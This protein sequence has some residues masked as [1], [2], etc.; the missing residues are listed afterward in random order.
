MFQLLSCEGSR[1][2]SPP[3]WTLWTS[4]WWSASSLSSVRK[5]SKSLLPAVWPDCTQ[6]LWWSMQPSCSSSRR[7]GDPGRQLTRVWSRSFQWWL[8]GPGMETSTR[9]SNGQKGKRF[10][11]R[12]NLVLSSLLQCQLSVEHENYQPALPG[13]VCRY[14]YY[15]LLLTTLFLFLTRLSRRRTLTLP[16]AAAMVWPG[17]CPP[18]PRT[19]VRMRERREVR[20]AIFAPWWSLDPGPS[21]SKEW[22]LVT[23]NIILTNI[24]NIIMCWIEESLN[25]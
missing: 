12:D 20:L 25:Y 13:L 15:S 6:V 18:T 17:C 11:S 19:S 14:S 23:T 2:P 16:A 22:E 1:H 5:L 7:G 24:Y 10:V 3:A 4:I 8:L 9:Q 21:R